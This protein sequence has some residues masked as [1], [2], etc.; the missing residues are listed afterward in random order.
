M[1][2][3]SLCCLPLKTADKFRYLQDYVQVV[4]HIKEPKDLDCLGYFLLEVET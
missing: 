4:C 1:L 3:T 2:L